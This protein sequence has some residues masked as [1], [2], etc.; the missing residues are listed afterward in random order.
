LSCLDFL[1]LAYARDG[2]R[3]AGLV[4]AQNRSPP[5][6]ARSA[7]AE[8]EVLTCTGWFIFLVVCIIGFL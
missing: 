5:P 8:C 6:V 3:V 1:A 2:R 7:P 4:R